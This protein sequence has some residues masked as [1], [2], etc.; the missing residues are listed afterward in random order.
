VAVAVT[1]RPR[2]A[3]RAL[4][5]RAVALAEGGRFA[6]EPNP[7]VGCV[8]ARGGRVV[9]Q[10]FH[11]AYGGPHAEVE[12]LRAAGRRARGATAWV[13][14]EPCASRGKTGP[15]TEALLAAGV[16]RVVSA[17]RDASMARGRRAR[18]ARLAARG[19]ASAHRPSPAA[20]ALLRPFEKALR[21]RRPWV[22]LK[23]ASS[24]DGLVA[25]RPGKRTRISGAAADRF[26]H[27]L[28]G[29]VEAVAVGVGTV[30]ADDPR[31]DC[32][33]PG[34]PPHGRPQPLAVVLDSRL[35]TPVRS[36]LVRLARAG[37]PLLLVSARPPAAR[38]RALERIPGVEVVTAPGRGGRVDLAGALR[39]LRRRGVA[40]LL[41]EAGPGV[42][43][44][45]VREGLVDQVAMIVA[46]S[47]LSG[48]SPARRAAA[49]MPS[50]PRLSRVRV[51][52][53]GRDALVEGYAVSGGGRS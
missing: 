26:V 17:A 12:A 8:L 18:E 23:W 52:R 32:R 9:G 40:R 46:P 29:R 2:A 10:G 53:L 49:S 7:L 37:R 21:A 25:A 48:A 38:R 24:L 11:R 42:A 36:R 45:L 16:R 5:E 6:V 20:W 13:S 28:R 34:G 14:L 3:E 43:G 1:R 39:L 22:V 41:V 4:L 27:G 15:C 50:A 33:L 47:T 30:L 51:R 35:R 31:L 44:A 19:L